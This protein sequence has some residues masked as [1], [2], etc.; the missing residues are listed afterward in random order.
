MTTRH[1]Y[2]ERFVAR[3]NDE[4]IVTSVGASA[5]EL[6]AMAPRDGSLYR[7]HLGGATAL[8]LGL[9]LALPNR[10]IVAFD[11][12]GGAMMGLSVLPV[13]ALNAPSNLIVIVFDNALYEGGGRLASITARGTDIAAVARGAGIRNAVAVDGVDA[14]EIALG[15]AFRGEGP[16]YI[17]ARAEPGSQA[18]YA[19]MDGTENKYRFIHHVEETE[20]VQVLQGPARQA[21]R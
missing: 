9:A 20:G 17:V 19:S 3:L 14:F 11:G 5:R 12:D 4:L 7:V 18:P 15:E 1:D 21:A 16:G 6:Q 8:A 2:L 10:R 13:V